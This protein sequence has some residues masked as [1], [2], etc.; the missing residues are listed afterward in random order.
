MKGTTLAPMREQREMTVTQRR[1]Y[2]HTAVAGRASPTQDREKGE[3]PIAG[4]HHLGEEGG[5]GGEATRKV[6]VDINKGNKKEKSERQ[7]GREREIENL[8]VIQ[9]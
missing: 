3:R 2:P 7:V 9:I 5:E 6:L 8:L 1:P 4:N